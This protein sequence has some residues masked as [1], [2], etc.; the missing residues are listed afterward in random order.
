MS[1]PEA[2]R[3]EVI[4]VFSDF[5]RLVWQTVFVFLGIAFFLVFL[6]K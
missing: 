4:G 2:L 6:G 1:L 3:A 5:L